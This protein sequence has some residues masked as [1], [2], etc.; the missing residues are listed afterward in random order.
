MEIKPWMP[1]FSLFGNKP[2][3]ANPDAKAS[4]GKIST[5]SMDPDSSLK[6]RFPAMRVL[7]SCIKSLTAGIATIGNALGTITWSAYRVVVSACTRKSDLANPE[8]RSRSSSVDS[9]NSENSFLTDV[10]PVSGDSETVTTSQQLPNDIQEQFSKIL[11]DPKTRLSSEAANKQHVWTTSE[12]EITPPP[13]SYQFYRDLGGT[14]YNLQDG[15]K[16]T[17]LYDRIAN[18]SNNEELQE[19]AKEA[20]VKKFVAFVGD[21]AKALAISK[22]ANQQFAFVPLKTLL[23]TPNGPL[24]LQQHGSG[25]PEAGVQISHT[26]SKSPNG[27]IIIR[28]NVH[29][30]PKGF[31]K[32]SDQQMI[33]L[34]SQKSFANF[35]YDLTC[36]FDEQ[37]NLLVI[38][39]Q[40][41]YNYHF[42]EKLTED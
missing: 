15:E 3:A 38:P 5:S 11:N 40:I 8:S 24:Q 2:T 7:A 17:Q 9:S 1:R 35:D 10:S 22:I 26:F 20:A 21:E 18:A 41:N 14:E 28:M 36:H 25:L 30:K 29:Q 16:V 23:K 32:V 33:E 37:G 31:Q 27:D 4:I 34:N 6:N 39:S 42:E 12:E 13:I 19:K